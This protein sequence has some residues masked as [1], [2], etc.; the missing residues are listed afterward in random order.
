MKTYSPYRI[1]NNMHFV[2]LDEP[3]KLLYVNFH[4]P[5]YNES[6]SIRSF[7]DMNQHTY[8]N[9]YEIDGEYIVH[10][11][12]YENGLPLEYSNEYALSLDQFN[13]IKKD[14]FLYLSMINIEQ[15]N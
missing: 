1:M 11:Y 9:F 13:A 3:L 14:Y 10:V 2:T 12:V 4:R 6:R 8:L 15:F 5:K 7:I